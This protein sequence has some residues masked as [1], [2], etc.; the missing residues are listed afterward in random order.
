MCFVAKKVFFTV[1]YNNSL[2]KDVNDASRERQFP[3]R[4]LTAGSEFIKFLKFTKTND[5]AEVSHGL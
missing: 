3:L 4:K 5:E 2:I 1:Y